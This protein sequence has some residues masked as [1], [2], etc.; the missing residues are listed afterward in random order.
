M[1][2]DVLPVMQG[3]NMSLPTRITEMA[4][5]INNLAFSKAADDPRAI[6]SI[7][8]RNDRTGEILRPKEHTETHTDIAIRELGTMFDKPG[9]TDGYLTIRGEFLNRDQAWNRAKEV[10]QRNLVRAQGRVQVESWNFFSGKSD[11]M[12]KKRL[13]D[14]PQSQKQFVKS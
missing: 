6:R 4:D 3:L 8:I 9:F 10:G 14:Y 2:A 5:A 7:A 1:T 13:T 12:R 11:V